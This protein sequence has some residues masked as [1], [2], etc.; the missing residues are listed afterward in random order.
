MAKEDKKVE[1]TEEDLLKLQEKLRSDKTLIKGILLGV[2]FSLFASMFVAFFQKYYVSWSES[3]K[4]LG[5]LI[6]GLALVILIY[7]INKSYQN[8][9]KNEETVNSKYI[10]QVFKEKLKK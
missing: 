9:E 10:R 3:S 7:A 6:C 4:N 2:V 5:F 1:F 8:V